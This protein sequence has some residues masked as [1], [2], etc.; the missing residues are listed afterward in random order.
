PA[1]S[2]TFPPRR[3]TA[4]AH[5]EYIDCD[6]PNTQKRNS[7]ST[8][9]PIFLKFEERD[10]AAWPGERDWAVSPGPDGMGRG[11]LDVERIVGRRDFHLE[12]VILK[13]LRRVG[14][15]LA[16]DPLPGLIHAADNDSILACDGAI[17]L[18]SYFPSRMGRYTVGA[19][20]PT[21]SVGSKKMA[22][23]ST[24]LPSNV[25]VPLTR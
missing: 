24:G 17:A 6:R 3:L 25:T 22:P 2:A 19:S 18:V 5:S 23:N 14:D 1:P 13:E 21:A 4:A 8:S 20:F 10:I 15:A 12:L 11:D 7:T 16:I 9:R